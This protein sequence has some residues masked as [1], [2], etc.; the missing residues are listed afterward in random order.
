MRSSFI[1]N[2]KV[3][4]FLL[5]LSVISSG[6]LTLAQNA[7]YNLRCCD[8]INPVGTDDKPYFGWYM[9]DPGD[10]EKQTAYQVL[11]ASSLDKLNEPESDLWNS[12][13]VNSGMQNYVYYLGNPLP[14][15]TRYYW[16]VRIWDK[17]GNISPWSSIAIFETG[18]LTSDDWFGAKWIRRDNSDNDD[19]TYFRKKFSLSGK[20]VQRAMVYVTAVHD[21]ELYLNGNL[22]GK[23]PAYHYPQYQ[24]YNAFNITSALLSNPD[25]IFACLT[26]WYG[27]GQGR[28]TSARGFL[29]KAVIEYA[30]TT[31]QIIGTDGTWKQT[32]AL[33][34]RTGQSQ[35]NGEGVGFIDRIDASQIIPDWNTMNYD[36]SA[37]PYAVEIGSHPVSPW[38]GQLQ[39]NLTRVV[40][41]EIT[42][43]S[44]TS[45]GNGTYIIDL[46]KVYAGVPKI[47]FSGGTAGTTVSM[48]GGFT[49]RTDGMVSTSTAQETNMNYYFILDGGMAV[50]QPMV[51]LG[52]R[53]FQVDNSP[54]ALNT[55][56]V[57]FICRHFELDPSR[58]S[59]NSSNDMLN[60]VWNLMKHS[61]TLGT[62][63]SFVDTPTREKGGFLGDSWSIAVPDMTTM[64]DRTMNLRILLEFLDSQDQY[65]PD[66]RLNAVYPNVDGKRDI[67]DY[68]QMY[69]VWAWDYYML[70]GN[71]EFLKDNYNRLKKVAGYVD[72]Y[73][74]ESTGLIHNLAG[75]G[76]SYLYG[77]IDWPSQMRYGYDMSVESRTVV[78]A[79]AYIDFEIMARIAEVLDSTA[80]YDTYQQK[81]LDM[82]EAIN[83]KL[84][85]SQGVYIDGL[86]SDQTQSVHVSQHANMFPL[87]MGIAPEDNLDS[88]VAEIKE[89]KMS[90]GMVTLR[91]LPEA[92][93]QADEGPHLIELYTNTEW[94]GWAKIISLGGTATWESWDAI[95]KGQ[96]LSHPWGAVGLLGIQ[97]YILGIKP[98]KPQHELILV[99]PLEFNQKLKHA[100]GM[101]P[102]DRGDIAISW[103]R[104][105][106]LFSMTLNLPDNITAN[107]YVPK[108]GTSGAAVKV[109]GVDTIGTEEGNYIY[110][111]EIGSGIH[112]FERNAVRQLPVKTEKTVNENSNIKIYPNPASDYALVDLGKEYSS[113]TVKVHDMIGS[114]IKQ[115]SYAN[116][117][118]CYVEL[119]SMKEGIFFVTITADRNEIVTMKLIKY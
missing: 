66:G 48:R 93:G 36:D 85:N 22:V 79:Y 80:D 29:L 102:T 60:Q 21:Y 116:T 35:R 30:D 19:Y 74:N 72:T 5:S 40:E 59:F 105:D 54:N 71:K 55:E 78:D 91:W 12:G 101:L 90:V 109:N 97:E 49:L 115:E 83:N 94:D 6:F 119:E 113:V 3:R 86:N 87:A 117:Q 63:D 13:Q 77:I 18:L 28:P 25:H 43:V 51:Y 4:L 88:I 1:S 33:A 52:M 64:G 62:Q 27:G 32:Q 89:Q 106:T 100:D 108:S 9:D 15:D 65:W 45:L 7:P 26:H 57:K 73:R 110:V 111:G 17:D 23:G 56:N 2:W 34:W 95:T 39:P 75:G 84:I 96:S 50:F 92:I 82:K 20:T 41:K 11:V 98:L 53:Y 47:I 8:K 69:L 14:A 16:K 114:T 31:K 24:Y 70:T 118:F 58:S 76:G 112:T 81:A 107:V 38:T 68:T 99:K 10:N 46:G 67:P 104:I 44:V 37:W 61:L 42:P 103:D